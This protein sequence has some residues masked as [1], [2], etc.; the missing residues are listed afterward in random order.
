MLKILQNFIK[1]K[2]TKI[3]TLIVH[4]LRQIIIEDFADEKMQKYTK[5]FLNILAEENDWF[6]N[7]YKEIALVFAKL[8]RMLS[9]VLSADMNT[10]KYP[11]LKLLA[12]I[13]QNR[14]DGINSSYDSCCLY[15]TLDCIGLGRELIYL[16]MQVF[17]AKVPI[18]LTY[19]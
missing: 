15:F 8:L 10:Y 7:T 11:I 13:W 14:K 3:D 18:F 6:I 12:S 17:K 16:M 4:C 1:L 19:F 5:F 9:F 2:L